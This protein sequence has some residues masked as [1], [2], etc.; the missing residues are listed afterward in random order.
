MKKQP[1]HISVLIAEFFN[2]KKRLL[3]DNKIV[4]YKDACNKNEKPPQNDV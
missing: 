1:V 3:A 2:A 4:A